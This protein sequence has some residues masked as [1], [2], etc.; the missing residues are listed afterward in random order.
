MEKIAHAKALRWEHNVSI[1]GTPRELVFII[2]DFGYAYLVFM[3]K[4]KWS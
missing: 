2:A 4:L 3:T 1:L